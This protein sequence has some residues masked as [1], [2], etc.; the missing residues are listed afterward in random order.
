MQRKK[1]NVDSM[2]R[3]QQQL[4]IN[5]SRGNVRNLHYVAVEVRITEIRYSDTMGCGYVF[6]FFFL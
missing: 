1:K 4:L 2:R 6:L 5:V 3:P